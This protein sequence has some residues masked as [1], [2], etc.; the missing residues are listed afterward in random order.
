MELTLQNP[1]PIAAKTSPKAK[2]IVF[3]MELRGVSREWHEVK[4]NLG[5]FP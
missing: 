4:G 2:T 3:C 5:R 1:A